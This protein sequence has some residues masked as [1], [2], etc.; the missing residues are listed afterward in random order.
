MGVV[1]GSVGERWVGEGVG[2]CDGGGGSGEIGDWS[3]VV[4]FWNDELC[5]FGEGDG[6]EEARVF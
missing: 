3:C 4:Y 1:E 6:G 2:V 5:V